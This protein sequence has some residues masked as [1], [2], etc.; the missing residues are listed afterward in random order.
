[1]YLYWNVNLSAAILDSELIIYI[2]D[3][4]D[5][6]V[7]DSFINSW[8]F[9]FSF[10]NFLFPYIF[11]RISKSFPMCVA[12]LFLLLQAREIWND[13]VFTGTTWRSW[14][15]VPSTLV[16][17]WSTLTWHI[18]IWL[19]LILNILLGKLSYHMCV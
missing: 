10:F 16:C 12:M 1:M 11:L 19:I 2:E 8:F 3:S 4:L 13:L 17:H 9:V 6:F 18:T 14:P 7:W 5:L 15:M